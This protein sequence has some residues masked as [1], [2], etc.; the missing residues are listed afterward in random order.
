MAKSRNAENYDTKGMTSTGIVKYDGTTLVTSTTALLDS[1]NRYKNTSQVCVQAQINSAGI[2]NV[3]GDG[4]V[5]NPIFDNA[6][7]NQGANYSTVTGIFTAP[8]T[9]IYLVAS[10]IDLGSLTVLHTSGY[11]NI[12]NNAT[13]NNFAILNPGACKD[14]G[15]RCSFTIK[16]L[17]ALSATQTVQIAT[18]VSGSTKTVA[19]NGNNTG[20]FSFLEI[21]L[22]C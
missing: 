3:T 10:T 18:A 8:V 12:I 9:G 11:I 6:L 20:A 19:I 5:Y 16:A 1:S 4:T 13:T 2:A 7:V 17:L 14:G 15:N 22:V 21:L